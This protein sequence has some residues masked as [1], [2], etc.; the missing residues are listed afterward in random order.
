MNVASLA[1]IAAQQSR[2]ALPLE[3]VGMCGIAVPVRIEGQRL[4][5]KADVGVSLDDGGARGIHMSR[6]YL[7]LERLENEELTPA[8]IRGL[9]DHFLHSHEGL[10]KHAYLNIHME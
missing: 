5:A 9:L 8:V 1:D 6:L 3:W 4:V 10:S 7:A 2:Q